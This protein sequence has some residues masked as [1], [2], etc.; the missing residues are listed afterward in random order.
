MKKTPNPSKKSP[1]GTTKRRTKKA[2]VKWLEEYKDCFSLKTKPV[3]EHFIDR[4]FSDLIQQAIS[5][6]DLL[7]IESYYLYKGVDPDTYY[8]W[9]N[10]YPV[11]KKLHQVAL[12]MIGSKREKGGLKRKYD[13]SMV[14]S[15]MPL[16]NERWKELLEWKTLLK[17]KEHKARGNVTVVLEEFKDVD[18][19]PT[20]EEVARK[21]FAKGRRQ[22]G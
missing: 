4:F 5:D 3:T 6:D 10:K 11:A 12:Y 16:Y 2:P 13:P 7:T 18:S 22:N 20:P 14:S 1:K 17:E 19:R 9:V 15:S 21:A 8:G